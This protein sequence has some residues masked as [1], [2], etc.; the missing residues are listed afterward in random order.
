[1]Y[2]D[3]KGRSVKTELKSTKHKC[4][5]NCSKIFRKNAPQNQKMMKEII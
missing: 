4:P 2:F 1:M 3:H 5:K